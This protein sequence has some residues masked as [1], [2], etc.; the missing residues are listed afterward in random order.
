MYR[1]VIHSLLDTSEDVNWF[2]AWI[3]RMKIG[4]A[5]KIVKAVITRRNCA[6]C[7]WIACC[8]L[9]YRIVFAFSDLIY[10]YLSNKNYYN[11]VIV[12]SYFYIKILNKIMKNKYYI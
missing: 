12:F 10:F 7:E 1:N 6:A 9:L 2:I 11:S 8:V 3:P 4:E 5:D